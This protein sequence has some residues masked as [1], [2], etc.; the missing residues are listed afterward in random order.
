MSRRKQS[1]P[2]QIKRS[3]G[4]VDGDEENTPD[5]L[6]LSGEEGGASDPDDSAEGDSSSPP[7][8]TSLYNEEPR[9]QDSR[10][11][12]DDEDE[13]GEEEGLAHSGG[14]E[15]KEG[16]EEEEAVHWRGPDDLELSE[17]G[18]DSRVVAGRDLQPDTTWGPYP[19]ILQS[20]GSTDDQETESSRLTLVCE[21]PDC[22]ISLLPLIPV[23]SAANC[24]IYS[25]GEELFCKVTREVAAGEKLLAFLSPPG[26]SSSSSPLVQLSPPLSLV[27]QKQ[28]VVKE[29]SL[30]P[31]A[32]RSDI[33]LLPQQAGMA[34]ILATAVVNKDIFPCKDCGIWYRSERNLQAHLMYYCASRQ[35]Q[36]AAASSPPQDKPKESYPNERICPF[37]QCNK[38]CPSASSLEIHMRTHSGE[39][40][41]VCLICLS[42]FTT[43]AN[44]ERHLKVHTD[45]LNGVCHGCGFVSTTRDILYSHLVTSHM[46]CQPGSRSEVYSPGPG[47]P[48]LPLSTGLSPGD[49]GVVLKC[50]VCGHNSD[51]PAQLQQHV[52]THLEVRVPAER[53]P[54]PRQSTPSSIDHPQ[55]QPSPQ[56]REPLACVPTPDSSSPGANGSSATPRDYS[57]PNAP[58]TD[59][60]IKEEPH[61]D[62]ETEEQQME[63]K[64][65]REEEE[66]GGGEGDQEAGRETKEGQIVTVSCQTSTSPKSPATATV[67]AEPTSP[68]PGS[69]PAHVG[70]AGSVLPGGAMFLPQYMFNPEAAILPQAS[71]ILAKMSEMVHSRLKQGQTVPQSNPAA[72]FP[73]GPTAP[74]ATATPPHKGATC[75]E[76]DITFNNINNFY[77]HKRLYCSSRHHGEGATSASGPGS[78]RDAAPATMP[79]SGAHGSSA[80]PQ[81][82]A[83]SRAASASPTNSDP[84]A[85]SGATESRRVVEVKTE[86]IVGREGIS[87]SSEGEGGGGSLGGGGGGGRASEG[88]QSPAS[89]SAEDQE[90][91]PNRTFCEACNIR[92]SRHENYT[93]H[94]RFY[95]ASRHDPSNQRAIHMAKA[96]TAAAFLPQ[97]IRKRKRKKMYEI[98]MAR[99]EALAN[100]AAAAAAAAT[101][102]AAASAPSPSVLG[103][104][105]KQEVSPSGAGSSSPEGDGPIDLSKRPRLSDVPRHSSS[106]ILPALPLTDYHKC[107]ACSISFNSIENYLAHKTYYCPATTLQPHTLEQ[108]HRLKR[109][110]STSP[111]SRPQ[112]ERPDLLH[113]MEAKALPA[114]WVAQVQGTSSS[115]HPSA[116]PASDATSPPHTTTTLAATPG[117]GAKGVNIGSS[118]VVC[119]YCPNR[120]I[121]CDLM[122]HFKTTHGLVVTIQPPQSGSA[123]SR[124]P[125][126]SPRDGA[127]ATTSTTPTSQPRLVTRVHRDSVNGQARSGTTS[128]VSPLVNGSPSAGGG[129]PSAGSPL[130]MSPPRAPSLTLS[131]VPEV[132]R[133]T[134]GSSHLPDT[135][136]P[137]AASHPV[138]TPQPAATV[139]PKNTVISPVLNGNSRFCRLCNIK[140]S[141][142]STFIA[143]KK[144]YCSSHS[145]EHVK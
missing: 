129:S 139:G 115:P 125:S 2:R 57:P 4:D 103:L 43:K 61:S 78:T 84:P 49:S 81:A 142:L 138:S 119:P 110:A 116:L 111:K 3:L 21:D 96:T 34:A 6:S 47:L 95:C 60:K 73:S 88:S 18:S 33:Q 109:S 19:G 14:E 143:H 26:A 32:L 93:V 124:S 90:D 87:S 137:T 55:L 106:S 94:K 65:D 38:S 105:V 36:P 114:E 48:K 102:A 89:G 5:N 12:P 121:T 63:I 13:D 8:Y 44:C 91:D 46:V 145:A 82:G 69:S 123:V 130:P 52:R 134:V 24:T 126:L 76:C 97:P 92:F 98:H 62:S 41:F 104:A 28:P 99:T 31:A 141:S 127:A 16:E 133:E 83:A 140:F 10:G 17:E 86:T 72:F 74:T 7:P 113:P 53:S 9:T 27:T 118:Q 79:S 77:A 40:P 101:A 100:A 71:E 58:T 64:E 132:L 23:V 75:F 120:L 20:E 131:P 45:T 22:W 1:K 50:Q 85:G 25:Q 80:S 54:T 37:P 35:K 136:V 66:I 39:R 128:P 51:S 144:Y 117:A 135:A 68:T 42:A 30:Y 108:L 56:E 15:E 59:L 107:T 112:Q 29:E 122:E 11:G 67:K 70:G